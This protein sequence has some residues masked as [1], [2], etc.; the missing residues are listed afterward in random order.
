MAWLPVPRATPAH[1]LGRVSALF[2]P[3]ARIAGLLPVAL[4]A[5]LASTVLRELSLTVA[6]THVGRSTRSS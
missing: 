1:F 3:T 6:G 5:W 2:L 4:A